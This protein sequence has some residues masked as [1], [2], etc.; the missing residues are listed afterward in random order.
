MQKYATLNKISKGIFWDTEYNNLDINKNKKYIIHRVLSL[1][2]MDDLR[3][4]FKI[5]PKSLI[6]NEFRKPVLGIYSPNILKFCQ[7]ILGVNKLDN[8]KY[9]RK[10]YEKA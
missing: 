1:G 10:F 5:Y 3:E 9:V 6:K 8:S 4:L 7:F 2:T